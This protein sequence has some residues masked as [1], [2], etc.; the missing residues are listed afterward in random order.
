MRLLGTD[1]G[2]VSEDIVWILLSSIWNGVYC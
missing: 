1:D 2:D